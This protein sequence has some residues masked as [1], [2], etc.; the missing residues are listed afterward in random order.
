MLIIALAACNDETDSSEPVH[1]ANEEK[2][3][4][5]NGGEYTLVHPYVHYACVVPFPDAGTPCSGPTD[6]QGKCLAE[7]RI[8][9]ARFP[10]FGEWLELDSDG[11]VVTVQGY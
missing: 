7:T 4:E 2:S 1:D 5:A 11:N 8:C 6:C 9:S 3:C 10:L